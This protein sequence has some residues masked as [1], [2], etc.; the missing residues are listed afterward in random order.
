MC[1]QSR[2][3]AIQ[4]DK[5]FATVNADVRAMKDVPFA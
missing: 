1:I 4:G 2:P 3:L 5:W